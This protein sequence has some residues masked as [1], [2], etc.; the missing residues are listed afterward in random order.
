MATKRRALP[1][2]LSGFDEICAVCE[3]SHAHAAGARCADC[4]RAVCVFCSAVS[5]G[6]AFCPDCIAPPKPAKKNTPSKKRRKP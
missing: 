6:E 2:W 4:D 3:R 5:E 1:Y